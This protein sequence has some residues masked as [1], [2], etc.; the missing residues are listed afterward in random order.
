MAF[1]TALTKPFS[2]VFAIALDS[3]DLALE[4]IIGS[5]KDFLN[6]QG[7]SENS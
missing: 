1:V 3:S 7:F 4:N 2:S 5:I 6:W